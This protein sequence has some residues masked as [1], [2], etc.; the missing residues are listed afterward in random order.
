MGARGPPEGGQ[1][2]AVR[3][4]QMKEPGA[5]EEGDKERGEGGGR[6]S[7]L[8]GLWTPTCDNHGDGHGDE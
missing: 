3:A 7:G 8:M 1:G 6:E 2:Q 4:A 5:L